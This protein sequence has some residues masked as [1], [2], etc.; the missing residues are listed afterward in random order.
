[1]IWE[2]MSRGH[3]SQGRQKYA[4]N[5]LGA[6]Y[7]QSIPLWDTFD[8]SEA[9]DSTDF[10]P[11]LESAS[12]AWLVSKLLHM[13]FA[14]GCLLMYGF[15]TGWISSA[16]DTGAGE[17]LDSKL[18]S[19]T[20]VLSAVAGGAT[21]LN[22]ELPSSESFG[23]GKTVGGAESDGVVL[24]WMGFGEV[25]CSG[26]WEVSLGGETAFI[27]NWSSAGFTAE[28]P[29]LISVLLAVINDG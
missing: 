5:C 4:G 24:G 26:C 27:S 7:L 28:P 22:S 20:L 3:L 12:F 1:M 25:D 19:D 15:L 9:S 18:P 14:S 23:R 10:R 21:C 13:M 6:E 29:T 16:S 2:Q 8:V 11:N 17:S